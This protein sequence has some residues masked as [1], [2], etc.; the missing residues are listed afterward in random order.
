MKVLL[1]AYLLPASF[2]F[3]IS[4]GSM[5]GYLNAKSGEVAKRRLLNDLLSVDIGIGS[6]I[7][8]LVDTQSACAL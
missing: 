3:A 5:S 2:S 8:I 6:I 4:F 7:T 1:T